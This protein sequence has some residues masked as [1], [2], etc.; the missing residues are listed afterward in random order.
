MPPLQRNDYIKVEQ[1]KYST[2]AWFCRR[3]GCR[4]TVAGTRTSGSI[5]GSIREN[6]YRDIHA[7]RSVNSEVLDKEVL[8]SS[9][10][11]CE[12]SRKAVPLHG[13][14]QVCFPF[15]MRIVTLHVYEAHRWF[16]VSL[17]C[18][19]S[20]LSLSLFYFFQVNLKNIPLQRRRRK[21]GTRS[22]TETYFT[23]L[24]GGGGAI[25]T[26][27]WCYLLV[28]GFYFSF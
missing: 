2:S 1:R 4:T 11:L 12:V 26:Q 20:Q 15:R 28:I 8:S 13:T 17:W 23:C 19:L 5:C 18:G 16:I 27:L 21:I 10:Y 9:L 7:V 24:E 3:A 6:V 14:P 22:L 25:C